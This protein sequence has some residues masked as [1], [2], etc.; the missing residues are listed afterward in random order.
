[1][2]KKILLV[3]AMA[4]CSVGSVMAQASGEGPWLVRARVVNLDSTNSD[5]TG[6]GLSINNKTFGE[7]DFTYFYSKNVAAELVLTTPQTQRVYSN[8]S[9]IGSF[10][11]LP[12]TLLLQYHFTDMQGFKPYVGAGINYTKFTGV[13]LP[14]GL[15]LNRDQW[16]GA[17]QAGVDIPLDKNWSINFDIKKVYISTNVYNHGVRIGELKVDPMLYAVGVGYR[18]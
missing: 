18:Y 16:G 14:P 9:Q 7:L 12:P 3:A 5:S 10:R 17:L 15:S 8:N 1:M 6:L 2:Q 4:A 13:S 11:H